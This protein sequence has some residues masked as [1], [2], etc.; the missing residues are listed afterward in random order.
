MADDMQSHP[1]GGKLPKFRY[2]PNPIGADSFA[3]AKE[4]EEVR[5]PCCGKAAEYYYNLRPY[6]T[7]DIEHLCPACIA[8]GAAAKKFGCDFVQ[9]AEAVSDAEKTEEL[10]QRT[11]G[12][13]TWQGEYWLAHCD[14]YMEYLGE[15]GA[16]ELKE[17]GIWE[18]VI[19]EYA[20]HF[21]C[22]AEYMEDCLVAG[23]TVTGY[24]FRCLHCGAYRIWV[25]VD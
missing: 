19:A 24:L 3:S 15:V 25:D 20:T 13:M 18:D 7:A 5:C 21:D 4:G 16:K 11:P 9:R 2:F 1:D 22:D 14:D 10:F 8:S 6:C 23:G 17:A 12:Y